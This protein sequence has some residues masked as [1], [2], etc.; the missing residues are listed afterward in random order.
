MENKLCYKTSRDYKRLKELLDK[1]YE[2]V[3]F[4]T[5]DWNRPKVGED[6][7]KHEVITTTDVCYARLHNAGEYS[8]YTIACR[9]T[10]FVSYRLYGINYS[11]TFEQLLES[12]DIEFIEPTVLKNDDL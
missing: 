11:Y 5:Y 6:L 3:C 8:K 2:V 9:G 12:E 4:I 7:S 10:E 1:G